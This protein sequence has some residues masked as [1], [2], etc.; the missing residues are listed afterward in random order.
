[1]AKKRSIGIENNTTR[2]AAADQAYKTAVEKG[3]LSPEEQARI[4]LKEV[5]CECDGGDW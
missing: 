1:V 4:T 5:L 3:L 2:A